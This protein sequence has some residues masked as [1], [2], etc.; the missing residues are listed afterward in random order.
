MWKDDILDFDI[1]HFFNPFF[2]SYEAKMLIEKARRSDTKVVVKPVFTFHHGASKVKND[3]S[4]LPLL[5]KSFLFF[6]KR[7]QKHEGLSYIDPFY[8]ISYILKNS[9]KVFCTSN[10]EKK[11]I[12]DFLDVPQDLLSII[13][14]GVDIN[15]K[16]GDKEEF[17]DKIDVEDYILFVGRIEPIKN[18]L[19][20][21][22][23]FVRSELPTKL[24]IVGFQ[25]D[26]QYFQM[27]KDAAN[28]DVIFHPHIPFNS[29]LLSSAYSG[30]KVFALPSY[31][32]TCGVSGLEAGLAGSNVV[33][34]EKGGTRD[35]FDE[36]A[37][38]VNPHSID[39]IKKGLIEAYN[40]PNDDIFSNYIEKNFSW[41]TVYKKYIEA[42]DS[43]F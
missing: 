10:E 24:V 5:E 3:S 26:P 8:N 7:C 38:Y 42:Y 27:C 36:F 40:S 12:I 35:Y 29:T 22:K 18:V 11:N 17:L 9:D 32:E 14:N 30:A 34:T 19:S 28:E 39:S 1:A 6:R 13:P 23:A 21:I 2:M 16:N 4:I 43:L 33:V 25:K 20:L 15:F 37:Y 41:Q 31:Y